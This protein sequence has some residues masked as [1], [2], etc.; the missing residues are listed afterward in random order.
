[1]NFHSTNS[2]KGDLVP[3]DISEGSISDELSV[4]LKNSDKGDLVSVKWRRGENYQFL[5]LVYPDSTLNKMFFPARI[6]YSF[7]SIHSLYFLIML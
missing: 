5:V 2:D 4:T 3:L 7:I 6:S 1:M